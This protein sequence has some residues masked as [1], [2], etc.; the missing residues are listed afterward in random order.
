MVL[1]GGDVAEQAMI[2]YGL[3]PSVPH[4]FFLL[5]FFTLL[6]FKREVVD[7]LGEIVQKI[8]AE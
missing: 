3:G 7:L 8:G 2:F 1:G 4:W 5:S 6:F